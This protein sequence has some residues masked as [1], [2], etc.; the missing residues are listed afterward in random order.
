L[1]P[2]ALVLD[3]NV[4]SK[5]EAAKRSLTSAAFDSLTSTSILSLPLALHTLFHSSSRSSRFDMAR[6]KVSSIPKPDFDLFK[7]IL[8]DQLHIP[9]DSVD[10]MRRWLPQLMWKLTHEWM[11]EYE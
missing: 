1:D 10:S 7:Q 6:T 8:F 4:S 3:A 2:F 9:V 5:V 11:Y